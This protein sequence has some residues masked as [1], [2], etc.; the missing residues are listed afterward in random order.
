[1]PA[2]LMAQSEAIRAAWTAAKTLCNQYH[3][4]QA[5]PLL[6]QVYQEMPRPL[7]CYWLGCTYE[8]ESKPDSAKFYFE[9][10]IKTYQ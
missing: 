7:C 3:Y 2:G 9:T 6:L 10:S 4:Q 1:M 8:L 5:K